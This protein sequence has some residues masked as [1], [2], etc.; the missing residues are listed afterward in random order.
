VSARAWFAVALLLVA[1]AALAV[2]LVELFRGES[3]TRSTGGASLRAAVKL[4]QPAA[5]PFAGLT[6]TE[7]GL[8]GACRRYVVADTL[9]ERI[10]GLRGRP[11]VGP[12]AGM[13]FVFEGPTTAGF[14][15]STVPVALDIAFYDG[16]GRRVSSR[17]M[18]PCADAEAQCPVYRAR[19]PFVYALETLRGRLGAGNLSTCA[20]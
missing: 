8:G 12:Y 11:D 4:A 6:E 14:T 13:L 9:G 20:A 7:L 15:M 18:R 19:E 10:E 2:G 17:H 5:S 1:G 16:A 3:G